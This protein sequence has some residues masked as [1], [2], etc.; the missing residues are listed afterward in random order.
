MA[1]IDQYLIVTQL[2]NLY[3]YLFNKFRNNCAIL[4]RLE[5]L[6]CNITFKHYIMMNNKLFPFFLV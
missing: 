6:F 2:I 1:I 3:M 5:Q 4:Y